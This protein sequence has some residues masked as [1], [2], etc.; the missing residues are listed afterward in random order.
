[1]N[2][3][4]E[5]MKYAEPQT[6]APRVY[7][8]YMA[9]SILSLIIGRRATYHGFGGEK[10]PNL[11]FII[12]GPSSVSHK[13]TVLRIGSRLLQYVYADNSFSYPNDGS[14]EGFIETLSAQSSGIIHADE[15]LSFLSWIDRDYN[16]GLMSL[17]TNLYDQPSFYSRKIGTGDKS[18]TYTI[19]NPYINIFAM[20]TIEWF[21]Q[22]LTEGM[23]R[24][25]FLPRFILIHSNSSGKIIPITPKPDE[26]LEKELVWF[27][28]ELKARSFGPMDYEKDAQDL[29]CKWYI[30][31][32]ESYRKTSTANMN[33][34]L[35][36]RLSDCHKFAMIHSILRTDS[37]K[38]N[39]EDLESAIT[40][41]ENIIKSTEAVIDNDIA[42]DP[43]QIRR[44]KVLA[45]IRLHQEDSPEGAQHTKIMKYS[46]LEKKVFISVIESLLEEE[47]ILKEVVSTATK[48]SSYYRTRE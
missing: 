6:S 16:S 17:L 2:F 20:S 28:T 7:H 48:S 23:I 30:S 5:Y 14:K 42:L 47:A 10:G 32:A 31:Y 26:S 37:L 9:Y 12:L 33:A 43:Y 41:T 25:G 13:S 18:K 1:M 34:F 11:W 4:E 29:F 21:N 35:Q 27:L 36:R 3:I 40:I 45:D 24:G 38:I 15:F 44:K 19:Q 46:H 22:K 39:K 8:Y